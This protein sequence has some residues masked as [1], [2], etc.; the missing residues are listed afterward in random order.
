[1]AISFKISSHKSTL[2]LLSMLAA[3]LLFSALGTWLTGR[4]QIVRLDDLKD[5]YWEPVK[6]YGAVFAAASAQPQPLEKELL[7]GCKQSQIGTWLQTTDALSF[8]DPIAGNRILVK[9]DQSRAAFDLNGKEI[10]ACVQ[11]EIENRQYDIGSQTSSWA[12][13]LLGLG[14]LSLGLIGFII[15][16]RQFSRR[17]FDRTESVPVTGEASPGQTV[18]VTSE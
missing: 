1:M 12:V 18:I 8:V 7:E 16:R 15:F 17:G 14:I 5:R 13:L 9:L 2:L 6:D 4:Y 10:S 11:D 3:V